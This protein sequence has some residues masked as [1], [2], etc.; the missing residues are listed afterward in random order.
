MDFLD[1]ITNNRIPENPFQQPG[2]STNNL[3]SIPHIHL[4]SNPNDQITAS[5]QPIPDPNPLPNGYRYA[6]LAHIPMF[7]LYTQAEAVVLHQK[8]QERQQVLNSLAPEPELKDKVA[9]H[10]LKLAT[11]V[12]IDMNRKIENNL[13]KFKA[14]AN[15]YSA[16]QNRVCVLTRWAVAPGSS[17]VKW[18]VDVLEYRTLSGTW[19]G[20]VVH[21]KMSAP[22]KVR[23]L[24]KCVVKNLRATKSWEKNWNFVDVEEMKLIGNDGT[25]TEME[26]VARI[27]KILSAVEA[28][29][30]LKRFDF[31]WII[32]TLQQ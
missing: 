31:E 19:K 22:V 3:P 1:E 20:N 27:E 28:R 21:L 26:I 13:K 32:P 30:A 15:N 23:L 5:T 25:E 7:L 11:G 9:I 14:A 6:H 18:F 12:N 8:Q 10:A 29:E 17:Q 16:S 4:P 2:Q 24:E